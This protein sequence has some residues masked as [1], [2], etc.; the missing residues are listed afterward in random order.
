MKLSR[1][2]LISLSCLHARVAMMSS[3]GISSIVDQT[4]KWVE[5]GVIFYD[6]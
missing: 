5:Y 2:L 3:F 6:D 4:R 1:L